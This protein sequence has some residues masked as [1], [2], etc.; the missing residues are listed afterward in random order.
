MG[1]SLRYSQ[2]YVFSYFVGHPVSDGDLIQIKNAT[3]PEFNGYFVAHYID[4]DNFA[5]FVGELG[6]DNDPD[7][8]D[9]SMRIFGQTVFAGFF[10][11]GIGDSDLLQDYDS[12]LVLRLSPSRHQDVYITITG[13]H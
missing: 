5:Y 8:G 2:Q 11:G 4:A 13:A 9:S 3:N 12:G 7:I 1:L 6:Y 10:Y